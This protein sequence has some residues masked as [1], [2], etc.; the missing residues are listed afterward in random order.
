MPQLPI[1]Y[2]IVNN[3]PYNKSII[4]F[5]SLI[6]Q[7]SPILKFRSGYLIFGLILF[8]V[9]ICIAKFFDKGFIRNT[10]G[11]FLVVILVYCFIRAFFS[12][13]VLA[14]GIFTLLFAYTIEILQYFKIV[15]ILGLSDSRFFRVIIGTSFEWADILAYTL[16]IGLVFL[17]E[18]FR[19]NK[20]IG[21]S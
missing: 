20:S 5:H 2:K 17:I 13:S 8:T 16:G 19:N 1:V 21:A 3:L 6:N 10:M 18:K 9:E 14:T 15:E 7:L 12:L 11:D 4:K